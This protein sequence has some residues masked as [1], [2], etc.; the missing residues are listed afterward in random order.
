MLGSWIPPMFVFLI[1]L[2]ILH[3]YLGKYLY[4]ELFFLFS[5]YTA[6]DE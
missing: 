3:M 1:V 5:Y 6:S 4:M 2:I